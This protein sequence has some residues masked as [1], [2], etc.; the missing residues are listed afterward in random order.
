M[1]DIQTCG[2]Y[3]TL[4]RPTICPTISILLLRTRSPNHITLFQF[5]QVKWSLPGIIF[6]VVHLITKA[7]CAP[8]E[9]PNGIIAEFLNFSFNFTEFGNCV[10]SNSSE[11]MLWIDDNGKYIVTPNNGTE[12]DFDLW[13]DCVDLQGIGDILSVSD[14]TSVVDFE[15]ANDDI[16]GGILMW[17]GC[18]YTVNTANNQTLTRNK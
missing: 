18:R 16:I 12:F 8:L 14:G 13:L 1:Q 17:S 7:V 5:F 9:M 2:D 3:R 4:W 11:I 6:V 10:S 15:L